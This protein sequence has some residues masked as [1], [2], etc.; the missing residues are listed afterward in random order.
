MTLV[1][2]DLVIK[3]M[4]LSPLSYVSI[5]DRDKIVDAINALPETCIVKVDMEDEEPLDVG[6]YRSALDALKEVERLTARLTT[7]ENVIYNMAS[8]ITEYSCEDC[9]HVV[10]CSDCLVD[11]SDSE[12]TATNFGWTKEDADG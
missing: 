9:P 1:D 7:A 6:K 4:C 3:V 5:I 8:F 11:P 2:K 10:P 12:K